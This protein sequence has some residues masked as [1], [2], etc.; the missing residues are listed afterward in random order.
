[1]TLRCKI[2]GSIPI[3]PSSFA[4]SPRVA[5][6]PV[7]KRGLALPDA[8]LHCASWVSWLMHHPRPGAVPNGGMRAKRCRS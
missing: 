2:A 4:A 1:M 5:E 8:D 7:L 3:V 6:E